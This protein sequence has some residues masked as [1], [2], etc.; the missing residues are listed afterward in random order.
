L[1]EKRVASSLKLF[2]YSAENNFPFYLGDMKVRQINAAVRQ[3]GLMFENYFK[4]RNNQL[5]N[6]SLWLQDNYRQIPPAMTSRYGNLPLQVNETLESGSYRLSSEW[7]RSGSTAT[8]FVRVAYFKD[9]ISYEDT[10]AQMHAVTHSHSFIAEAESA[11]RLHQNHHINI[12]L[13]NT[14]NKAISNGYAGNPTRNRFAIFGSYKFSFKNNQ[15]RTVVNLRQEFIGQEL[16]PFT[17]SAGLEGRVVNHLFLKA[18]A[19]KT[20]R[21]PTFND[22]YWNPGGNSALKPE[23]GWSEELTLIASQRKGSISNNYI[24]LTFF[25]ST[26]ENCIMWLPSGGT[27]SA[28]NIQSVWSR[29][30][31]STVTIDKK[32]NTLNIRFTALYN[33]V[34]ATNRKARMANDNIVG[35]QLIYVPVYSGQATLELIYKGFYINYL[36]CYTGNRYYTS[37][38]SSVVGAYQLGNL[39][40][41]KNFKV[42]NSF[43]NVHIRGNNIWNASY[44]VV[45]NQAMPMRSVQAGVSYSYDKPKKHK[46]S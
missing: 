9:H 19:S 24:S 40:A 28:Q 12:G 22:L 46:N 11:V 41:G 38:N 18:N 37:D 44:Q 34:V 29:G 42:G 13:N 23:S 31:E 43:L 7:K 8:S 20:Y 14:F 26:L 3:K 1:S 36:H 4:I 10:L 30:L 5:L 15:W 35:K 21:V 33:Y 17:P 45:L 6:V 39:I 16:V 25:N 2:N 27:W 32:L